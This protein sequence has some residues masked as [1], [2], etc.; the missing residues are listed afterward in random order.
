MDGDMPGRIVRV[1]PGL[2]ARGFVEVTGEG[3]AEGALVEVPA[4]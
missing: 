3:L 2:F 1:T 4:S